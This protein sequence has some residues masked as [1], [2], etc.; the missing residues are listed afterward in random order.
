MMFQ[1][2]LHLL[3][4]LIALILLQTATYLSVTLRV[5]DLTATARAAATTAAAAEAG[6]AAAA[7]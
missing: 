5:T 6:A 7:R 1:I 4:P 2:F 3:V